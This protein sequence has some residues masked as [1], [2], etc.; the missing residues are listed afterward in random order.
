ME[1]AAKTVELLTQRI[2]PE[3]P[4][5]LSFDE[6]WRYSPSNEAKT[7]EEWN[8]PRLQYLTLVSEA[9]RGVLLTRSDYDMREEVKPAPRDVNAL[10]KGNSE[11]KKLSLSDYRNKKTVTTSTSPP[12]PSVARK[13]DSERASNP[14]SAPSSDSR[15]TSEHKS[16]SDARKSD[17]SKAR[18]SDPSVD[19]KQ[20]QA[21]DLT[22]DMR[23]PPKPP[24]KHPLPPRP[25]S[26]GTRKRVADTDE[27]SRPQKRSKPDSGRSGDDRSQ[28]PRDDAQ[29][30]KDRAPH[31]SSRD[32]PSHREDRSNHASSSALTNGRAALKNATGSTRTVSPAGRSR[33]DSVNGTR[34]GNTRSTPTK[35]DAHKPYVPPLLSPLHLSFEDREDDLSSTKPEK[36]RRDEYRDGPRSP[37]HKKLEPLRPLIKGKEAALQLRKKA[38]LESLDGKIKEEKESPIKKKKPPADYTDDDEPLQKSLRRTF[39]V[40][41]KIPKRLKSN[42]KRMMN[43][44]TSRKEVPAQ[45]QERATTEEP[46]NPPQARKRPVAS[47]DAASDTTALKKPRAPDNSGSTRPPA[48]STPSKKG[49]TA[50]SRVSS[51]N[52]LAQTPGEMINAT[53]SASTAVDRRPN[54]QD[55][56]K[57]E[58]G[59]AILRDKEQKFNVLGRKLK[60]DADMMMKGGRRSPNANG[61]SR[62]ANPRLGFVLSVESLL[63]FM[64]GFHA[65]NLFRSMC[66]KKC[67]PTGWASLFPFIDFLQKEIRRQEPSRRYLP[68]Y[69]LLLLL[70]GAA[71]DELIKCYLTLENPSA[72][73]RLEDILKYERM[74]MKVWPQI[75]DT[76]DMIDKPD[77]RIDV[78]P[79]ATLDEITSSSIRILRRWCANEEVVWSPNDI[80]REPVALKSG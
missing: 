74:R 37:R 50:M 35:Q 39:V 19:G 64:G 59:A 18:E 6:E 1:A 36:K 47:T 11:K 79:W 24:P 12:E 80:L 22:L 5:H 54:G 10:A 49:P 63:A 3:K 8:H 30:R 4:H 61:R 17:R 68:L 27:E 52:S 65:Q 31:G 62:E 20:R 71:I 21:R 14:H 60:H 51:S 53:P 77:L 32:A 70:H 40:T 78:T 28:Q 38:S 55:T 43:L 48:P 13:R 25:P 7:F 67:D 73:V 2:L 41:L 56:L 72:A 23:L 16:A 44:S 26:P 69:S 75:R 57:P 34:S 33:G 42:F 15:S 46:Q 29:R 45:S 66:N 9:D 76:N 58:Q